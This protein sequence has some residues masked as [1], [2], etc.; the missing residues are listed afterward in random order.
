MWSAVDNVYARGVFRLEPDEV[1]LLEGAVVPCDYW[2]V[3]LW[4]PFLGSGDARHQRVTIN[5]A[6]A[7][8]GPQG[9][10]RVAIARRDPQVPDVDWISTAGERQ[11]TFFIR[12]MC[13][14]A[15][16][17]APTCRLLTVEALAQ[18]SAGRGAR[19]ARGAW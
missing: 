12:W 6:Q 17:P 14:A 8:L 4:S 2:G 7:R 19:A 11:G 9:E 1:L 5:T 10:F 18:L 3:Q 13:P 16:P 15:M